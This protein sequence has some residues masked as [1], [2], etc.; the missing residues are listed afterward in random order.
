MNAR[1]G[2]LERVLCISTVFK[3]L[4]FVQMEEVRAWDIPNNLSN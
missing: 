2:V 4:V 1:L 3:F